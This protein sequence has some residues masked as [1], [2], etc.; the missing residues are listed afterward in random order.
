MD[1][2]K[3][4]DRQGVEVNGVGDAAYGVFDGGN[5]TVSFYKGGTYASIGLTTNQIGASPQ[6]D[7][8]I[9]LAR[10]AASRI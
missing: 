3:I 1:N 10:M 4:I 9:A 5:A 6:K 7:H 8:A 2:D